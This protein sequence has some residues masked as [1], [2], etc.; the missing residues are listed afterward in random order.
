MGLVTALRSAVRKNG[1][2]ISG[3]F[4]GSL[5]GF[6]TAARPAPTLPGIPVFCY[7][8]VEHEAFEADLAHLAR[9]GYHTL[10]GRDFVGYLR[11]ELSVPER[12]VLLTFDDG[13]VNFFEVAFP[14]LQKYRA[15]AT[16]FVA[17]GLH[18]DAAR[19]T[20]AEARPMT[21]EE[22]SAIHASGLVEFQSH[23]LESR[24]VPEWPRPA[25]LSGVSWAIESPRRGQPLALRED[26]VRSR[27]IL[28]ARLPGLRVS[29]LAFP[30]Y[31]GTASAIEDARAAGIEACYWGL[32]PGRALNAPGDC[33]FHVGRMS[34]EFLR[35]LPGEG[36][37]S[38]RDLLRVRM[39]RIRA[40]REWR[41]RHPE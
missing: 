26:L 10:R 28:E 15:R 9:N 3:L 13:P 33:P 20:A 1:P 8:L 36:R 27:E 35:R 7:H 19:E 29:Q 40:G 32:R 24:F 22:I 21:W 12:S 39:D 23:T 5:P 31:L 2:E 34:D 30:M 38:V 37:M 11:R 16:A 17:P 6:V 18:A 25:S 41:R 4:N 14:L